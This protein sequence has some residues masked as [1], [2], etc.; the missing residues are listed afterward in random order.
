M[1][2]GQHVH[3]EVTL[4]FLNTTAWFTRT[5]LISHFLNNFSDF[6]FSLG[7]RGLLNSISLSL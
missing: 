5:G 7:F 1:L 2:K 3:T 4:G 6:W